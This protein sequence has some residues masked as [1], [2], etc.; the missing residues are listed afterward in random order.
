VGYLQEGKAEKALDSIRAMLSVSARVLRDG[1][2]HNVDAETLVP[3]DVVRI[4]S[5]DRIPAD[6]RLLE[7]NNLRVEESALTGESVPAAKSVTHVETDAG[8]GDRTSMVYSGTIVVAG[9]GV[10]VV[11]ATGT[12]TEIGRIQTL[13]TEIE[14]IDTPLT[15]KL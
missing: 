14:G 5:G 11:T 9:T 7:V 10:G 12:A 13:I 3:G 6:L 2:W 1:Q 4:G 15:R 8:L